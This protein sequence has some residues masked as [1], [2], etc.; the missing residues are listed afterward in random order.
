MISVLLLLTNIKVQGNW[1][2]YWSVHN[3][4]LWHNYR[5]YIVSH[6]ISILLL[7]SEE[8]SS[9]LYI[10]T[11]FEQCL[12]QNHCDL[13]HFIGKNVFLEKKKLIFWGIKQSTSVWVTT[14][15]NLFLAKMCRKFLAFLIFFAEKML[16][17]TILTSFWG[18]QH[19]NAGQNIQHLP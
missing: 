16:K 12:T 7:G 8:V 3:W 10:S 5:C 2:I 9:L 17:L 13:Q 14:Q 6:R 11:N 15:K 4:L 18:A 1:F 19:P